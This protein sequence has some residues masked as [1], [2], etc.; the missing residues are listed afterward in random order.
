MAFVITTVEGG[1]MGGFET[2]E[3]EMLETGAM[4]EL[5]YIWH[6]PHA[7]RP[8]KFQ[9][10]GIYI[11]LMG[12]SMWLSDVVAGVAKIKAPAEEVDN[13]HRDL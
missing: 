7:P 12:R 13:Q 6:N 9:W 1:Y 5:K 2:V 11:Q 8:W 3:V 10:L 4:I